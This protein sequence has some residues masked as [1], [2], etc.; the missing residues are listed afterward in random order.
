MNDINTKELL[1]KLTSVV[2]VSGAEENVSKVLKDILSQYGDVTVD[3]MN[4]VFCTFGKGYHFLL[5]AHLDEIGLIVTSITDDGFLKV[6]KCGGIDCR[7]LLSSEVS[8]WTK[9]GEI[10]GIISTIPPHLQ[11]DGD[12]KKIVDIEDVSIDIGLDKEVAE[13]IVSLGDRVT[14]RRNFTELLGTQVSSSVLDDRSGI[15]AII[16]ALE[17]LKDVNAKITVMF[18][19]QEEVNMTG[20]KTGPFG[21]N[22]DEAIAVDVSFGYSP[23]CKK[24]ECKELGK[25]AMIGIS[26]ILDKNMSHSLI[27][28]A[29][30]NNIPYQLEVMGGGRTGTNADAITVSESGI[31]T[32][33]I[34]IPEKY[35]HSPIEIVDTRD[36]ESVAKLIAAYVKKRAGEINA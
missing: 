33:L 34:S 14:F 19:C 24:S 21:K 2:G 20:S 13:K 29:K 15:A 9:S 23:L 17:E 12:E 32:A 28:V 3:N 11:K 6:A 4:N 1:Y 31:K 22:I 5:D 18:S 27:E 7:M 25:G 8:I 30:E 16:L 35:M 10:K 36:V 26:P